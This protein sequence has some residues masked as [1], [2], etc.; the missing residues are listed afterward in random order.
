MF[1]DQRWNN[2]VWH[3][4]DFEAKT[5][6]RAR[7]ASCTETPCSKDRQE[8]KPECAKI[9]DWPL[10]FSATSAY[11]QRNTFNLALSK[12]NGQ[13]QKMNV[14]L[15]T[16]GKSF[17][18]KNFGTAKIFFSYR[19]LSLSLFVVLLVLV[20]NV[21]AIIC[22]MRLWTSYFP[23]NIIFSKWKRCV[24]RGCILS[25][26][27]FYFNLKVWI[28]QNWGMNMA[29]LHSEFSRIPW[30]DVMFFPSKLFVR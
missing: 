26:F 9:A 11:T 20:L 6:N 10:G 29:S 4:Y 28:K 7:L 30:I 24:V 16:R 17:P 13:G 25:I 3:R 21:I 15:K 27:Y 12:R 5:T 19:D 14:A 2:S 23:F 8:G 22:Q 18:V 1:H